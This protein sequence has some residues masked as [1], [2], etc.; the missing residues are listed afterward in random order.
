MDAIKEVTEYTMKADIARLN[1][2]TI[3][4]LSESF[5]LQMPQYEN[6][7]FDCKQDINGVYIQNKLTTM[8]SKSR[9]SFDQIPTEVKKLVNIGYI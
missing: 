3:Q 1:E 4:S 8:R 7:N 9:E 5:N 6:A 2:T